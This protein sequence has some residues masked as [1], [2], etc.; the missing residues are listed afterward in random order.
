MTNERAFKLIA[1]FV[2]GDHADRQRRRSPSCWSTAATGC[3]TATLQVGVL[4]AF[5]LYL[6]R[7][8]DPMQDLVAVLQLLPVRDRGA[9]EAL[10][11]ARGGADG[12]R[13]G[14]PDA[15]AGRR[16]ASS[17]APACG[18]ATGDARRAAARSTCTCR[19]G[20]RSRWSARTGAGKTT[21]A[22]LVGPLLRPGR[23]RGA[24]RRRRPARAR[25]RRPAARGRD[26]DP[27]ELP[28]LRHGRRQHRVRPAGRDRRARSRRRPQAIGAHDFI[29]RAAATA[30]TPTSA[31]AAAGSRP[32]SG[33]WSRSPGRSWPTRRC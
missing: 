20:R 21:I 1:V 25:R 6:R 4:T 19:P 32:G 11:R 2:P 7:F 8:F 27:G 3:S 29:T 17:A 15:A 26:G 33:S 23:G 28:V 18:S 30:T 9:G 31:S 10:R 12:R 22:R 5:L 14:R 24:A 13:A 16:A